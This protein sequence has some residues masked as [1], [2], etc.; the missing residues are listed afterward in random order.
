MRAA[1]RLILRDGAPRLLRVRQLA[2]L[3]LSE[4]KAEKDRFA[5]LNSERSRRRRATRRNLPFFRHGKQA[6]P[7]RLLPDRLARPADGFR[8]LARLALGGFFVRLPPLHFAK[9]ALALQLLF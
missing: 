7:L 8:L 9:D 1:R 2:R 3:P 6:F 4:G 5:V